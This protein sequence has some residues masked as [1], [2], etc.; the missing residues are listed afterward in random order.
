MSEV[1]VPLTG[2]PKEVNDFNKMAFKRSYASNEQRC[3][4]VFSTCFL[5]LA[6]RQKIKNSNSCTKS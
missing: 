2:A 4:L 3:I 5:L 1:N 6:L